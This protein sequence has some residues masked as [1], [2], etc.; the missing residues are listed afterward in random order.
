MIFC[1]SCIIVYVIIGSDS[2][3]SDYNPDLKKRQFVSLWVVILILFSVSIPSIFV[4]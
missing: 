3:V 2:I 4:I 1:A